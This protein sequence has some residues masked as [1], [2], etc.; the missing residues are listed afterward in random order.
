MLDTIKTILGLAPKL[1]YQQLVN[2]GAIIVD[3]RT[4]GEYAGGHINK[5]INIPLDVLPK[6]LK[7][8]KDKNKTVITCCASGM[9]SAS[10]KR[11]LKAN[12]YDNV[13]NGGGWHSLQSKI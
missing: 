4:K 11:I 6:Q 12:G 3:V 2:D 8:L 1:D 13:H 10:A 9:R 7:K 5:S